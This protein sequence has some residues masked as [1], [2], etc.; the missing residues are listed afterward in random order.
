MVQALVLSFRK[1]VSLI[2]ASEEQAILELP[3]SK[4]T[5]NQLTPGLL[6]GLRVLSSGGASEDDI[7]DLV[8]KTD[9]VFALAS[10]YYLLQRC[11][12]LGLLCYTLVTEGRP[13]ATMVPMTGDFQFTPKS[14]DENTRFRLSRFAYCRRDSNALV[15][16]SPL[17]LVRTILYGHTG[18][19]LVAELAQPRTYPDLCDSIDG[20]ARDM[21]QTFLNLLANAN[22][23]AEVGEENML[24]EDENPTLA[25]WSFADLLFHSRSRQGRHDYSIGGNFPFLGKIAP[26]PALKPKMSEDAIILY[27]PDIDRLEQKDPPF[28]RVLENR[29]SIRN[30]GDQPI[31]AQQLGEFLYR[32]VRVRQIIEPDPGRSLHYQASSRPYPSGGA[33]YDLELY[34]TVNSCAEVPSG[35]YHYDPLDHQLC[36]L[37]DR[38]AYVDALLH[39]AKFSAGLSSEPQVLI[40]LASRFQ[41]LSWKYSGIAYATTL[42]NVGVLY[43]TMYLVATAMGLAP[44]GLGAGNSNIFA[45]AVGTDYFAESS[46]GEF[47]LGSAPSPKG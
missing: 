6:A 32:V 42:K 13:V 35:I 2:E 26:L 24:P 17:S 1:E 9:G 34:V 41:R 16:E 4:A 27:K 12:R 5:L 14:M 15:L 36:R 7:A 44:C 28:T 46:V 29:K 3:W 30:Y 8:I 45:E 11:R 37:V 25:Q 40:T 21:A 23:I 19:A 43:Q 22:L 38:N 10:M 31:T 47:I 39:D 20:L 18:A 33:T